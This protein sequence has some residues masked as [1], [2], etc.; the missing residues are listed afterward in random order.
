MHMDNPN[1]S[2]VRKLYVSGFD[3]FFFASDLV[4]SKLF[5]HDKHEII[6]FF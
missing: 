5:S 6:H 1:I 4:L 2:S 3:S